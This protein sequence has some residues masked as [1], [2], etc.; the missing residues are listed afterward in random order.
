MDGRVVSRTKMKAKVVMYPAWELD[1]ATMDRQALNP[2]D[3]VRVIGS[4]GSK[5]YMVIEEGEHLLKE[6]W[7]RFWEEK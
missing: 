2:G 3:I 4:D 7:W 6:D 5:R 1:K